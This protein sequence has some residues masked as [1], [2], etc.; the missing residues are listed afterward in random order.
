[1]TRRIAV[2]VE[3]YTGYKGEQTPRAFIVGDRKVEILEILD[4][5]FAPDHRYFK[6]KG[7]DGG[8]YIL[9][10][11]VASTEWEITLSEWRP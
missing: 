8:L 9:R 11:D 10:H 2:H 5:W 6:V 4:Q 7:H 1:M 3:C